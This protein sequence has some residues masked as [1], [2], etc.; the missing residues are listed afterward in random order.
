MRFLKFI[1]SKV[2][3]KNFAYSVLISIVLI[4]VVLIGLKLFTHH[5]KSKPVPDFYGLTAAEAKELA[6]QEKLRIEISDSVY[7]FNAE[8]GTIV[9]QN[10]AL[11]KKVKKN[12]M[13]FL[14]I[15]AVNPEMVTMPDVVG[16]SHRQAKALIEANGLK[17]GKLS[18]IPDVAKNNVLQQKYHGREISKGDTIP[19]GS[20]IDLVLGTGLSNRET[21]VPDLVGLNFSDARNKILHA[22]LNMGAV[23]FDE[24]VENEED[25]SLAFIWKQNPEFDEEKQIPL[26]SPVYL[27]MT[28]DST[29]LPQP[30]SVDIN[31]EQ[32]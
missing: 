32:L 14:T 7:N 22:S 26:G 20:V 25:S 10:P 27:W 29:L 5:G 8:R 2:F 23:I 18:Y 21:I 30:D 6:E 17:V 1:F 13:V 15:N 12:R 19:K 28:L 4:F 16:V 31:I 11:G 9:E 3:L 24:T